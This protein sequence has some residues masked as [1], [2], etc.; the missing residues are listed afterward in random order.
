MSLS[1]L[2]PVV[3]NDPELQLALEQ[4]A[5]AP[6]LGGDI[7]APVSLRPFLVAALTAA[8][9]APAR[10]DPARAPVTL[11]V[12][13]LA[14]VAAAPALFRK[15]SKPGKRIGIILSGGNLDLRNLPFAAIPAR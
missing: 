9:G 6:S 8:A 3:S 12:T 1:G 2:V 5:Q 13:A 15:I 11:A 4:A 7:I 14:A 10:Q